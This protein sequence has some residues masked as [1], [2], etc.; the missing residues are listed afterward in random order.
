MKRFHRLTTAVLLTAALSAQA[1]VVVVAA[2][3]SSAPALNKDTA[4]RL[5]LGKDTNFPNGSAA[6]PVDQAEDSPTRSEFAKK[7]LAKND[8]QVRA[9]WSQQIFSGKGSPPPTAAD[10]TAVKNWLADNPKGVGYISSSAV[11]SSVKVLLRID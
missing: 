4:A 2:A 5:F 7:V 3:N 9:Y 11:D 1:G 6:T 10:D 8:N